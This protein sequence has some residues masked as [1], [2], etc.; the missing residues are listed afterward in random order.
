MQWCCR[1]PTRL[2]FRPVHDCNS[3]LLP[4]LPQTE[5]A[6]APNEGVMPAPQ[7]LDVSAICASK[8]RL[9]L[10]QSTDLV[11]LKE[12]IQ[13]AALRGMHAARCCPFMH[14]LASDRQHCDIV[15]GPQAT[16]SPPVPARAAARSLAACRPSTRVTSRV[17]PATWSAACGM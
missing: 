7:P 1:A 13:A 17:L 6:S 5:P 14:M 9:G 11:T 4:Q 10:V 3:L 12:S 16:D 15:W 8:F 2:V